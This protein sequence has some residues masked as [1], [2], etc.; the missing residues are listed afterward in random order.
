MWI[1]A[2]R[3]DATSLK[4]IAFTG[5]HIP[6][7]PACIA[8]EMIASFLVGDAKG[9]EI[10]SGVNG[11]ERFDPRLAPPCQGGGLETVF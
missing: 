1:L 7:A 5:V 11:S 10:G 3:S 4:Q 8:T 6:D 9:A 2:E